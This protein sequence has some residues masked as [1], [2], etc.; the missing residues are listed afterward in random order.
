MT[1]FLVPA[2]R[3]R[4]ELYSE[5]AEELTPAP[6]EGDG[7]FRRWM[8]KAGV[9]WD[10]L[11]ESARRGGAT[12][13]LARWRDRLGEATGQVPVL[14]GSGSTWYVD[15]AHPGDGRVVA[16]TVPAYG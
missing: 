5:G 10:A 13:R 12:G 8:H 15:G 1:V 14:A 7:R 16:R 3:D 9:R 11:V 6:S 2:G 4:F